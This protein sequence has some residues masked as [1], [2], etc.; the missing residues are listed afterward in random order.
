M[1]IK[2]ADAVN[3]IVIMSLFGSL[4]IFNWIRSSLSHDDKWIQKL[5]YSIELTGSSAHTNRC[6]ICEDAMDWPS[7]NFVCS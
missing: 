7:Q 3:L 4:I 2:C 6:I 5:S 1:L